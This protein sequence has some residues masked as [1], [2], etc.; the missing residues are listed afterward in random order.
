MIQCANERVK[1][2]GN[3][4][5]LQ[6]CC[7]RILSGSS[8]RSFQPARNSRP[9]LPSNALGAEG[10]SPD[11]EHGQTHRRQGRGCNWWEGQERRKLLAA[12]TAEIRAHTLR[13]QAIENAAVETPA[14]RSRGDVGP[15]VSRGHFSFRPRCSE[16][17]SLCARRSCQDAPVTGPSD[18]RLPRRCRCA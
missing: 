1:I 13:I 4:I 2:T 10:D 14:S 5:E 15:I 3:P 9:W 11:A 16:R 8:S 7:V 12:A 6:A 18:K 17:R